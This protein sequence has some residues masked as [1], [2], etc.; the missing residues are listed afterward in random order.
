MNTLVSIFA[1]QGITL[2]EQGKYHEALICFQNARCCRDLSDD[3]RLCLDVGI[4]D[5]RHHVM[6]V[7]KR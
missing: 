6:F 4:Q 1:D 5:L 2:A 3:D 7:G